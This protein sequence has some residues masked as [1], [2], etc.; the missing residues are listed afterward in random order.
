MLNILLIQKKNDLTE[1]DDILETFF[2]ILKKLYQI[3]KLRKKTFLTE[4]RNVVI[5]TAFK[6]YDTLLNIY[7]TQYDKLWEDSKKSLSV[8]NKPEMLIL[9]FDDDDWQPIPPAEDE[10]EVKLEPEETITERIKLN[11]RK[12][13]TATGLKIST[14]NKLLT[15]LLILLAHWKAGKNS[16]KLKKQIKQILCVLYQPN[17]ITKNFYNSLIKPYNHGRKCDCG[18]RCKN[19]LY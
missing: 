5:N 1:F 17:K 15:R 8:I 16:C 2:M 11:P 7:K 13:T 6:L 10:K 3:M 9:D 12:K 18:R 19:F 14:P 4:K